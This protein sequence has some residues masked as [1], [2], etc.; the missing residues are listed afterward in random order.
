MTEQE[1]REAVI[2]LES[3][4][5]IAKALEHGIASN[6]LWEGDAAAQLGL[7]SAHLDAARRCAKNDR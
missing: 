4:A 5:A 7:L 2:Y 3:V 1:R 6:T